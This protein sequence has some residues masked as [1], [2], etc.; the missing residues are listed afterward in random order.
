AGEEFRTALKLA[1]DPRPD[2]DPGID[3]AVFLFRQGRVEESLAPIEAALGRHPQSGRAHLEMGCILL[4]LDRLDEAGRHL[5]HATAITPSSKRAHLL[6]GK[7]YLR[8]GKAEAAE[9][10]LR[11]A[12]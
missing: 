7:T 3:Y 11:L 12:R 2:E 1:R 5:E 9:E 6:L 10:H 4:A 8:L